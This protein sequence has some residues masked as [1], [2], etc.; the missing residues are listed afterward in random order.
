[1]YSGLCLRGFAFPLSLYCVGK[2]EMSDCA[3]HTSGIG[4]REA[5]HAQRYIPLTISIAFCI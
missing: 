4:V 2:P 5:E 1:M 3:G